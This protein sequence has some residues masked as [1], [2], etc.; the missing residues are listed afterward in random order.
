MAEMPD[1]GTS[2]YRD[3]WTIKEVAEHYRTTIPTV[4]YWRHNG[5]G[6]KGTRVGQRVLFPRSEVERFD[7]EIAKLAGSA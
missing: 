2:H 4:R 5:Y 6:P 1:K 7:R 3:F